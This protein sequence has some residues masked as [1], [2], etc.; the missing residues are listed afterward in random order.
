[1]HKFFYSSPKRNMLLPQDVTQILAPEYDSDGNCKVTLKDITTFTQE[2][3]MLNWSDFTIAEML[4]NGV[5]YDS[6]NITPDLRI[7]HEQEFSD[8]DTR[9]HALEKQIFETKEPSKN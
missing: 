5:T 3:S 8:F 2:L 7:G 1:M 4:R 6:L 9:F